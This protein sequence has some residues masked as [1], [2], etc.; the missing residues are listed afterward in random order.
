MANDVL[1]VAEHLKGELGEITF[2]LLGI[3]KTLAAALGG[4]CVVALIGGNDGMVTA[5]GAAERVVRV[6]GEGLSDF[7]PDSHGDALLAVYEAVDPR[8]VLVGYTSMGMDLASNLATRAGVPHAASC[9]ALVEAGENI[10]ATAQLYGGKLNV[11]SDLGGGRC[12]ASVLAGSGAVEAG[13]AEGAPATESVAAPAGRGRVRFKRLIEPE[14][15]DVDITA[16]EV[17]VAIGRGIGSKDD[18]EVAEELAE[19][20]D[21]AVAGSRPL[22]DSGWLP[23]TRQVG[24]SGLK[25]SPKLYLALGVSGAPEHIEGMKSSATIV[26]VN[27]DK[28]APIFNYAHYGLVEDLF[29][30]CEELTEA[31]QEKKG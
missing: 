7:D 3:G 10:H 21:G 28:Q 17:L 4:Q 6:D 16:K 2:E 22:I 20:L 24:K 26:A 12:V 18:I 8:V 31:I 19:E 15:G 9:I 5:L 29:D 14:A 1:V 25:V 13:K 11:T 23:K 27:T 30:V